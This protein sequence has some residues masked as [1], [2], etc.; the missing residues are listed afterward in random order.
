[1]MRHKRGLTSYKEISQG[2]MVGQQPTLNM[3]H[4]WNASFK[5]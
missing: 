4:F 5:I 1:V 2:N 3:F